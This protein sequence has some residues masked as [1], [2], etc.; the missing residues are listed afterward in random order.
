MDF[1]FPPD[2]DPRH[3]PWARLHASLAADFGPAEAAQPLYLR[4]PDA[5]RAVKA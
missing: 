1:D 5:N 4:A 2:D 3:V